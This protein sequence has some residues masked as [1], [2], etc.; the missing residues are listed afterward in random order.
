M[1]RTEDI[2]KRY[3]GHTALD[4]VSIHVKPQSIFGLLGPNGAGKTSLI[5]IIN[6]ITGP[7]RG[8]IFIDGKPIAPYHVEIIGY[9]P[10]ER[11]LYKKMKVGEQA[12][13]LAKLKGM[14]ARE[15]KERL[16]FWF[17]KFE[18]GDWWNKKIEDLSKGMA[19]KIQFITTI[20]HEPKLLILD[21]PFS[22]FDPIN[23]KLIRDEMLELRKQGTTIMLSTHNMGSVEE[24]CDDIALI[25]H[26]KV[27]LDGNVKALK[28]DFSKKIYRIRFKGEIL[29]FTNALWT[30]F[31][32]LNKSLDEDGFIATDIKILNS[33]T[34]NDLLKTILPHAQIKS[35]EELIPSMSDIFIEVVQREEVEEPIEVINE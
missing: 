16:K 15:A 3:R 23:A 31:E 35:V 25:N 21:E 30:N 13:Y 2:V 1:L 18:A 14:K 22:G 27:V 9:L 29:G 4:G 34:L 5:R 7:D 19:Q 10:E 6:Q 17:E 32:L 28:E 11:G 26:A 20:V 12:L 24:I 33:L 8:R